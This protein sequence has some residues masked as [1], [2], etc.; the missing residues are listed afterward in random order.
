M[1]DILEIVAENHNIIVGV[2][3]IIL[4]YRFLRRLSRNE[5]ASEW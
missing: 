4:I 1:L 2:L 5:N 3:G